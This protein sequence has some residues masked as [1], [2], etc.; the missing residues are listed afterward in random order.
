MPNLEAKSRLTSLAPQFLV[1]DLARSMRYYE[2]LGFTFGDPWEGFY[3]IG[4]LDGLE[5]HLKEAPAT[6][7]Y[8]RLR[9]EHE[10]LDAAAGVSG[11][12][13]FYDHCVANGAT[14]F[15]PLQATE[16]GTKDFYIEDPDGNIISFG[17]RPTDV[18]R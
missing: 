8:R 6:S 13:T 16:W 5:L 10:H 9:H 17:G 14:I 7:D 2:K 1:D 3:A 15:K 12:E 18:E 11:I 4:E